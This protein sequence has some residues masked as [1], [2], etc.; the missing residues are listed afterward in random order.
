MTAKTQPIHS[1][2]LY[3]LK[4]VML[5]PAATTLGPIEVQIERANTPDRIGE[6][7]KQAWKYA[8]RKTI[9]RSR[10]SVPEFKTQWWSVQ[11]IAT[12]WIGLMNV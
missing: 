4:M 5:A 10:S 12:N 6:T 11:M 3:F 2:G 7:A 1:W 9:V 8:G